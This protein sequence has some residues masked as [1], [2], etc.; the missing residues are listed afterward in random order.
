MRVLVACEFSGIVRDAFAA[1][2]ADAWSCDLLPTERPG[3]HIQADVLDIL[4]DGWDLL[5]AHPPCTYLAVMGIWWN[6][7]QPERWPL[8]YAARDFVDALW[9]API[10]RKAIENP[11]GW[12]S[13]NWRK[14]AQVVNPWWFGDEAHKPTC[15]W[16]DGLRRL[17][18]TN[19]VG[20]GEFYQKANGTRASVWSHKASGK[21]DIRATDASRTF[22]GFAQAMADTWYE[23]TPGPVPAWLVAR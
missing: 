2:G 17:S 23:P 22:P 11:I 1:K 21:D 9:R 6:K 20:R 10:P 15:L 5:I 18:P 16:L 4:D 19:V 8:T 3:N 14:P 13:N 7:K 12:L